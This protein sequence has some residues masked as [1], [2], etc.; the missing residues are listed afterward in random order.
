[1]I[2]RLIQTYIPFE[3]TLSCWWMKIVTGIL[4]FSF[5][6]LQQAMTVPARRSVAG[7]AGAAS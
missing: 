7:R 4:M 3:G 2:Q 5:I 6:A 1:M